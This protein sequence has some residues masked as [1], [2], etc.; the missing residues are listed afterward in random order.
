MTTTMRAA[1]VTAFGDAGVIQIQD[2]PRPVPAAGEVLVDVQLTDLIF[3]ETAIRAGQHG[4]FFDV[5]PP[6]VPGNSFGG[7]VRAVGAGV[8]AD[9]IGKT[10]TGRTAS[11]GAH[12]EQAVAAADGLHE[13][14]EG[15]TLE[16][17]VAVSGDGYTA[18]MLEEL[19]PDL[20]GKHVLITAAA[21]GMGILLVQLAHRAGAHVIAAARGR[22]K[23][24]LV[25]AH[26][27]DVVIDYSQPGW[28]KSV[29]EA[30]NGAG[31]DIVFEGAGGTLGATAF[32]VTADHGWFSAHGAP[33]GGFA[34]YDEADAAR[35]GITVKGILDLRVD[36]TTTTVSA[37]EVLR[38]AAAGDLVPVVDRVYPLAELA[39]AHRAMTGR[40][41]VGKA[42][43]RVS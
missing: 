42:L 35:R 8:S 33:S 25:R 18:L 21:G 2:L 4:G 40:E 6:Y 16:T 43:I 22:A 28:E 17:A 37:D 30:T 5:T 20:T 3:V 41:L 12:A 13:V 36:T 24:G 11:F 7:V 23:L 29:L 32:T 31:A 34:A 26:H 1:V 39:D 14:P 19:V 10:V 38:R 15:L 27:A 9:W